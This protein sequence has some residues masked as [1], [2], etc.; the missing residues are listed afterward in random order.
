MNGV[1]DFVSMIGKAMPDSMLSPL[2]HVPC[3]CPVVSNWHNVHRAK[4]RVMDRGIGRRIVLTVSDE[5][6]V[7]GADITDGD[8]LPQYALGKV[9]NEGG[10]VLVETDERNVFPYRNDFTNINDFCCSVGKGG[11]ARSIHEIGRQSVEKRENVL[12]LK[13]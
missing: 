11:G 9:F 3:R 13:E 2:I 6:I 12:A 1:R 4:M 8:R 7:K 5:D 10:F